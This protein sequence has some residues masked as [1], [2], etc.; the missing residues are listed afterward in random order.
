MSCSTR[1]SLLAALKAAGVASI[2]GSVVL[3]S[4]PALA[5]QDGASRHELTVKA[6][7]PQPLRIRVASVPRT[8]QP[9]FV[10][11][12]KNLLGAARP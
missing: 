1:G 10:R 6:L 2:L 7:D 9:F 3:G 12:M 4:G 11:H 8:S 5:D